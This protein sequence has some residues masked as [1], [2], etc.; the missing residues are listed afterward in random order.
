MPYTTSNW[1]NLEDRIE[2]DIRALSISIW[3]K[4]RLWT[5]RWHRWLWFCF[6]PVEVMLHRL[7]A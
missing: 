6:G 7:S 1:D 4:P 3:K 5:Y 2:I